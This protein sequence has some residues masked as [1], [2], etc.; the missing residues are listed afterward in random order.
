MEWSKIDEKDKIMENLYVMFQMIEAAIDRRFWN[1]V[2]ILKKF[3]K[4][5]GTSVLVLASDFNKAAG[6]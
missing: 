2:G 3:A 1:T 6:F 4:M 5:Q